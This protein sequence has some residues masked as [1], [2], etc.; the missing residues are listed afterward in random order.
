MCVNNTY[1]IR[2]NVCFLGRKQC[3]LTS[4]A[5]FV[6]LRNRILH[7]EIC[8]FDKQNMAFYMIVIRKIGQK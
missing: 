3:P 1:E 7:R 4:N 5:M 2:G 6:V 8:S